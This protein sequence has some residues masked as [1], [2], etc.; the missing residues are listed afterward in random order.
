MSTAFL[1][2]R[3]N[4]ESLWGS[5]VTFTDKHQFFWNTSTTSRLE[6]FFQFQKVRKMQKNRG[7]LI[8]PSYR[9]F[10][11][12]FGSHVSKYTSNPVSSSQNS[13]TFFFHFIQWRRWP[14]ATNPLRPP[15]DLAAE[16]P[17]Q[18]RRGRPQAVGTPTLDT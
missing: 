11:G 14:P 9:F 5:S 16:L 7:K 6:A 10:F 1:V 2:A 3:K 18:V 15:Q 12:L 8:P 4:E 13:R 17:L